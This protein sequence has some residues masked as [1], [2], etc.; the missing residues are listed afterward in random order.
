M[1]AFLIFQTKVQTE[2]VDFS[3]SQQPPF[4]SPRAFEPPVAAATAAAAGVGSTRSS[5]EPPVTSIFPR[6]TTPPTQDSL[7][8]YTTP[9]TQDSLARYRV[10]GKG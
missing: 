7:A 3:S 8:R 9:P 10:N 1:M 5:F 2:P 6:P 4:G